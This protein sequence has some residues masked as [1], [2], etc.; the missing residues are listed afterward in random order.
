MTALITVFILASCLS[1][2]SQR[3]GFGRATLAL[4]LLMFLVG[5]DNAVPMLIFAQLVVAVT[6][7]LTHLNAMNPIRVPVVMWWMV[8]FGILGALFFI[9]VSEETATRGIGAAF[10]LFVLNR[11]VN[12]I[13]MHGM[14]YKPYANSAFIGVLYG[15]AGCTG[16]IAPIDVMKNS[17]NA[18]LATL[19][20]Y[21]AQMMIYQRFLEFD[22]QFWRVTLSVSAAIVFAS[23]CVARQPRQKHYSGLQRVIETALIISAA[24]ML[25]HGYTL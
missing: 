1:V 12:M 22:W 13:C 23:R 16:T 2:L 21:A 15:A 8:P 5:V 11:R 4:P 25:V 19:I 14:F 3:T 9:M 6:L 7:V 20:M 10:I 24:Y 17:A 18:S